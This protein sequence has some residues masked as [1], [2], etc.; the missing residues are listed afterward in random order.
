MAG[1]SAPLRCGATLRPVGAAAIVAAMVDLVLASTSPYRRELLERLGVPFECVAPA[2]DEAAAQQGESSPIALARALA[3]GKA[4]AVA[5]SHAKSVVVGCDQVA[6]LGEAILGKPGSVAAAVEQL[7]RLSGHEHM[8]ITAVAVRRGKDVEEFVDVA[9]LRM[10]KLDKKEIERYVARD[11]P[12][13]CAGAY[14]I[15]RLGIALFDRIQ[16]EDHTAIV[17]LPLLKLCAALRKFGLP[18]P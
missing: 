5:A 14:K 16:C 12:V 13:D 8:L 6:A 4:A 18:V 15:E 1:L 3:A 9:T 2:F 11:E 7:Q 17:G 10:R